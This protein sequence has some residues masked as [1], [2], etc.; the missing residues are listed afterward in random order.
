MPPAASSFMPPAAVAETSCHEERQSRASTTLNPQRVALSW[1]AG[2]SR[3]KPRGHAH[4]P[5]GPAQPPTPHTS[6]P[7]MPVIALYW[8][9]ARRPSSPAAAAA[10][11][12]LLHPGKALVRF[13]ASRRVGARRGRLGPLGRRRGKQESAGFGKRTGLSLSQGLGRA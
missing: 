6:L 11:E 4:R 7:P 9:P 10:T 13:G 8:P 12:P 1:L 5:A 2:R 3:E